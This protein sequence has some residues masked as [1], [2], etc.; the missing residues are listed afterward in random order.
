MTIDDLRGHQSTCDNHTN[1]GS[2]DYPAMATYRFV[3]QQG[4][5]KLLNVFGCT[6]TGEDYVF[7][8]SA[9]SFTL[10]SPFTPYRTFGAAKTLQSLTD[11]LGSTHQFQYGTGNTAELSQ[12]TFPYGGTLAWSY[13]TGT[14]TGGRLQREA[15]TRTATYS[16]LGTPKTATLTNDGN[17]GLFVHSWMKVTDSAGQKQWDFENT[18]ALTRGF[19]KVYYERPGEGQRDL[20]RKQLGYGVDGVGR[21]VL[22]T[23]TSQ[24]DPGQSYAW[25]MTTSGGV[26][27]W[28]ISSDWKCGMVQARC[29]EPTRTPM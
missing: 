6:G 17:P 15:A 27:A 2:A 21:L 5:R 24:Y 4:E 1:F 8:Y 29:C 11:G 12:I 7:G 20:L 28:G 19:T 10:T 13:G 3:W 16:T 22:T 18:D 23:V 9:N 14:Y 26:D 25:S